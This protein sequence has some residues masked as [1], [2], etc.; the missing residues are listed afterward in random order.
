MLY[1][2]HGMLFVSNS[3]GDELI[4]GEHHEILPG[5]MTCSYIPPQDWLK[6]RLPTR[7][8]LCRLWPGSQ[9]PLPLSL[10]AAACVLPPPLKPASTVDGRHRI[11]FG[12]HGMQQVQLL[13]SDR[14]MAYPNSSQDLLEHRSITLWS[15]CCN[16]LPWLQPCRWRTYS[17]VWNPTSCPHRQ[18]LLLS[19]RAGCKHS[20]HWSSCGVN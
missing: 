3:T 16:C 15:N 20:G 6:R 8:R 11:N 5:Q 2:R 7:S 12:L 17:S 14:G 10:A 9:Q 19:S 1:K 18:G 13:Y 4:D